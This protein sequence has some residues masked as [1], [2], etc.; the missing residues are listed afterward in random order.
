MP[1]PNKRNIEKEAR[2]A[3]E[4]ILGELAE[5]TAPVFKRLTTEQQGN[6]LGMVQLAWLRGHLQATT[7][8]G[9]ALASM[10]PKRLLPKR[11]RP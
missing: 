8:H 3:A 10:I 11:L 2:K 6:V 9:D 7:E 4:G 1:Q 5:Q